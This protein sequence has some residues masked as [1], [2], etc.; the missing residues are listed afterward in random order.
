MPSHVPD[1]LTPAEGSPDALAKWSHELGMR[2][3]QPADIAV[4]RIEHIIM[5]QEASH[6]RVLG[7]SPGA[8][9]PHSCR[10]T[11]VHLCEYCARDRPTDSWLAHPHVRA[12]QRGLCGAQQPGTPRCIR[13]DL[14][15]DG[16]TADLTP[17]WSRDISHESAN[18]WPRPEVPFRRP[19]LLAILHQSAE[20]IARPQS[21][22]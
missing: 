1:P 11:I 22:T 3:G 5:P 8:Q 12:R 20:A 19:G 18:R 15:P 13:P 2:P 6:H 17:G 16:D 7:L 4:F 9:V 10:P 14:E 21:E